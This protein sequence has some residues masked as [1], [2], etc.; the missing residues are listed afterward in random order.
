MRER[1]SVMPIMTN[2][3]TASSVSMDWPAIT[4]SLIRFTMKEMLRSIACSQ[5][6]GN[7]G[8]SMRGKSGYRKTDM[9][10]LAMPSA[11]RAANSGDPLSMA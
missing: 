10:S 6:P 4:R 5:P 8:S 1:S 3:R 2:I 11:T 7:T 9:A